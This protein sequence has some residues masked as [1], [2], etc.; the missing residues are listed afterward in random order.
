VFWQGAEDLVDQGEHQG[1]LEGRKLTEVFE[2]KSQ[3][4]KG[5]AEAL[6]LKDEIYF[7]RI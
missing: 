3:N 7:P 6:P 5:R 1:R 4:S 2:I